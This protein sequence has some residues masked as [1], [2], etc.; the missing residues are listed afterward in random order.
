MSN[1]ICTKCD[2]KQRHRIDY[3]Q[4]SVEEVLSKISVTT[5]NLKLYRRILEKLFDREDLSRKSEIENLIK[6]IEKSFPS[7]TILYKAK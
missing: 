4:I 7:S 5:S 1:Y 3:I 6:E 2:K